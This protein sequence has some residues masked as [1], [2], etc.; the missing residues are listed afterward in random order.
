MSSSPIRFAEL[1]LTFLTTIAS[2]RARA[3][4]LSTGF[5]SPHIRVN[6]EGEWLGVQFVE[7]P[8][9]VVPGQKVAASVEMMYYPSVDY[10]GV[11]V[12][13]NV[14]LLEGPRVVARGTVLRTWSNADDG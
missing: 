6:G 9:E 5:Y 4:D 14:E 11:V 10:S 8:L 3:I 7:A 2:G 13:S 1:D 12:G